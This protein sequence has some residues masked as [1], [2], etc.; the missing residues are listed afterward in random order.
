MGNMMGDMMGQITAKPVRSWLSHI[1]IRHWYDGW[2]SP[3]AEQDGESPRTGHNAVF[4][5]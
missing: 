3:G 5:L 4:W 2:R 1:L